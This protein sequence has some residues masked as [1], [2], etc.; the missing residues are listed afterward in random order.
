MTFQAILALRIS[1]GLHFAG[2]L[3]GLAYSAAWYQPPHFHLQK[4]TG[5]I[6]V[7]VSFVASEV[8]QQDVATVF[9]PLSATEEAPPPL[10]TAL[11][12]AAVA[13][14]AKVTIESIA[15]AD[16]PPLPTELEECECDAPEHLRHTPKRQPNEVTR[17]VTSTEPLTP[18]TP[19]QAA[20]TVAVSTQANVPSLAPA[21]AATPGTNVDQQATKLPS[22][23]PP[24]YP[25]DAYAA[26][27]QGRLVL[28]VRIN[29]EGTVDSLRVKTSSGFPAL[30]QSA[31]DTVATWRFTPALRA[32]RPVP[33][34]VS[35]PVR[36][37]IR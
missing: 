7:E 15:H 17:P 36:F 6:T 16:V 25:A 27:Q 29:D 22:N 37:T 3:A 33:T 28:E 32:G 18:A 12:A 8:S 34:V 30:D 1:A 4:G 23:P 35:V 20:G 19:K 5:I 31:L 9:L 21:A 10:S 26:G 24:P 14:P 2:M 11:E 13:L